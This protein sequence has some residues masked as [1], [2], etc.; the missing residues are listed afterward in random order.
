[1]DPG[2]HNLL[3]IRSPYTLHSFAQ[4]MEMILKIQGLP[5]K[6]LSTELLRL[7]NMSQPLFELDAMVGQKE[8]KESLLRLILFCAQ[9][10]HHHAAEMMNVCIY[11]GPGAGKTKLTQIIADIFYYSGLLPKTLSNRK[12]RFIRGTRANLISGYLG[13]T[14]ILTQKVINQCITEGKCLLIDEA[15]ALHNPDR[16]DSFSKECIDTINQN[17]SEHPTTFRLIVAG[18]KQ[19]T[20]D[21]FFKTNRGL[22]RRFGFTYELAKYSP[23]EL[24]EMFFQQIAMCG[25]D[26]ENITKVATE[27]WFITHKKEFTFAGGDMENLAKYARLRSSQRC[28]G[29][30]KVL[31]NRINQVDVKGALEDLKRN[32]TSKEDNFP[33]HIYM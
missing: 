13:Q 32:R 12:E 18:Y 14:A 9:N 26:V 29:L 31:K 24:R 33:S 6:S 22:A 17:L 25:Y 11:A 3:T 5:E 2:L 8:V 10:L 16:R 7:R 28:F 23:G 27:K 21:C 19:E 4:L 20:E 30:P 15:Y 1:M